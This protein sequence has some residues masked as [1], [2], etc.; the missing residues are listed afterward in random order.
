[1]LRI[2]WVHPTLGFI[3]GAFICWLI[4]TGA[5]KGRNRKLALGVVALL[6]LQYVL[7]FTDIA[8]LAPTWM[9]ILHLLGAD[10]LW[11]ALVV[12]T[13]RLCIVPI[14]CTGDFCIA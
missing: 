3:A 6:V 1:M 10:V 4:F 11:I 14:G 5:W 13:A 12:L 7:G 9:Q 8:L 2:R